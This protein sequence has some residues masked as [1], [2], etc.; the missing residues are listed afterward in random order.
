LGSVAEAVAVNE[1]TNRIYV[2]DAQM[3]LI[4]VVDGA[5]NEVLASIC[6]E[7]ESRAIA[8]N[9]VTNHVYA[10]LGG[11]VIVI[12]GVTNA[13]TDK[14]DVGG[15]AP[16]LATDSLNDRLYVG[17]F[18]EYTYADGKVSVIVNGPIESPLPSQTAPAECLI[19]TTPIVVVP[20]GGSSSP[21]PVVSGGVGGGGVG[22]ADGFPVTGRPGPSGRPAWPLLAGLAA[23]LVPAAIGGLALRSLRRR[24]P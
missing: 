23:F 15:V 2:T 13:I 16:G 21:I 17:S 11:S 20:P 9:P 3:N 5:T 4:S 6:T 8:V 10:T 7:R 19:Q 14:I 18:T 22:G 12:D 24:N 1:A